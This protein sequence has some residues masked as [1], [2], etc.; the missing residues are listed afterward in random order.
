MEQKGPVFLADANTFI[1][2]HRTYYPFDLAPGFWRG[3]EAR[4]I[5]GSIVVLD[6]VYD[7]LCAGG[8]ELSDWLSSISP[9]TQITHK[10]P[11]T[12][13]AY[14]NILDHIQASGLY[15]QK[16]LAEW[17]ITVS[18]I[19]GLSLARRQTPSLL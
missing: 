5:D 1:T 10:N 17:S 3:L 13:S 2:P 18:R 19:L 11:D 7:E 9:C 14:Q 8:D 6:K 4:I 15:T 16:A 12:I